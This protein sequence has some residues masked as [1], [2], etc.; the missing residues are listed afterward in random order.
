M[1]LWVFRISLYCIFSLSRR[2]FQ[3]TGK[4]IFFS[5]GTGEDGLPLPCCSKEVTGELDDLLHPECAPIDIPV[6]DRFF[7]I[8]GETCMEFARSVP[9]ER[10]NLGKSPAI[11]SL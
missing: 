10:C 3:L 5:A 8:F 11:T 4:S 2:L 7:S 6:D 9:A 1:L